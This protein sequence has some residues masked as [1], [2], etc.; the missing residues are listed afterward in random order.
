MRR[1]KE[2]AEEEV[3]KLNGA[4]KRANEIKQKFSKKKETC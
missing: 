3:K 2:E 1:Q 4:D